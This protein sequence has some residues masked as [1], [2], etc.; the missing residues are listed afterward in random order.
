MFPRSL[1]TKLWLVGGGR[2]EA[3]SGLGDEEKNT[4]KNLAQN[5]SD[6]KGDSPVIFHFDSAGASETP[7]HPYR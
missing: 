2:T 3:L 5:G 7:R 6:V 4:E 1:F